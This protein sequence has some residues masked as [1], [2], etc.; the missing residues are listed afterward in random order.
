[1]SKLKIVGA[2]FVFMRVK[3]KYWLYPVI[4]ALIIVGLLI[5]LGEGSSVAPFIYSLF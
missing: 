4:F 1:M 2:F 3:R 5:V